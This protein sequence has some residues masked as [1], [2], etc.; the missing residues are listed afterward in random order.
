MIKLNMVRT[1]LGAL[2]LILT[3][4]N[5]GSSGGGTKS[6][7]VPVPVPVT[8]PAPEPIPYLNA[9]VDEFYFGTR[10]VGTR[11]TQL[12]ELANRSADIYPIKRLALR[13]QNAEEFLLNFNGEVTLNPSE[14]VTLEVSFIPL[15]EGLKNASLDIDYDIVVKGGAVDSLNEQLYYDAAELE[16]RRKYELSLARYK[17]YI[18]SDPVT[19]N[20]QRAAIKLPVIGESQKYGDGPDFTQYVDAV[21]SRDQGEHDKALGTLDDLLKQYPDSYLADD[22]LYLKGYIKL[23]DQEKYSEAQQD[24]AQLQNDF[25]E[26]TYIDTAIYSE[27]LALENAGQHDLAASKYE[28]LLQ[29]HRSPAWSAI[30]LNVAKDN[31]NSRLWFDRANLGLKRLDS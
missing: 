17:S 23:I 5:G 18:E 8:A 26:S 15:T 12:I 1:A 25:P 31:L 9:S 7:P 3:A 10:N 30:S 2:L 6:A 27:A 28:S 21:N 29:R 13:G 16:K 4:C 14:K 19:P 11:A 22:A 20:K 24:L